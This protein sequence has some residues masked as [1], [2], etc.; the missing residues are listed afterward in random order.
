MANPE[1]DGVLM[2]QL[3]QWGAMS[4]IQDATAAIFADD[5]DSESADPRDE[6]VRKVL[7]WGETIGTMTKNEL[8]SQELILDW[9]WIAGLWA[10]VGRAAQTAREAT[11]VPQL[12]ENFEALANAQAG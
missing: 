8:I 9:L 12:Y 3:A 1:T 5:F 11:G 10:R 6:S 7:M 4:G 2:I